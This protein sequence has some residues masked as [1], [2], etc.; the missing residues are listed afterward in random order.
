MLATS[1]V[2]SNCIQTVEILF[3][4]S[5]V[6]MHLSAQ[7]LRRMPWELESGGC[8]SW[9]PGPLQEQS[10]LLPAE[11]LSSPQAQKGRGPGHDVE[12]RMLPSYFPTG[13]R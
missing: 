1:Q 3:L 4:F 8:G 6:C 5:I 12:G 11:H 7:C 9:E 13:A 2:L 10:A